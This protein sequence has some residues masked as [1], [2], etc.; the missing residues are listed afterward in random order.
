VGVNNKQRRAAKKRKARA[1]TG[2]AMP[3]GPRWAP[4][5]PELTAADVR[6]LLRDVV[7]QIWDGAT[8]ARRCAG[9][10]LEP[11]RPLT[12]EI[13]RAGVQSFLGDLVRTVTTFGWSPSDL[14]ELT[15]RAAS[16]AH[17][18]LVTGLLREDA[19]RYATD[20]VPVA[21]R[22][23]LHRAGAARPLTLDDVDGMQQALELLATLAQ[24]PSVPP[25]ISAPGTRGPSRRSSPGDDKLLARVQALLAKAEATD[26][27]EEAEALSAKAQE[28]VSRHSLERLLA[29]AATGRSGDEPE[30]RRLWLDAPYVFPKAMLVHV[31][32]DA[33]RCRSVVSEKLGFCTL[34]GAAS[35]LDAVDVLVPSLLVQA[36]VAMAR[37]GRQTDRSGTSRTRSFRQSFLLAYANRIGERLRS[38]DQQAAASSGRGGE[39]VPVLARHREQVDAACDELFPAAVA[40][41]GTVNNAQGWWAGRAAADQASIGTDLQV[42]GAPQHRAAS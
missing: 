30:V 38:A 22:E 26:F 35:D 25:V 40:K 23:D 17:V 15:R 33:N 1:R 31:V 5:E 18:P 41:T 10:L 3:Q 12:P 2:P 32:A 28:L 9:L 14:V 39:L 29:Q 37:C 19:G 21:W 16:E 7:A 27:D 24:L 34:V 13:A 42:T 4:F 6:A 11:G 36:H 8:A 20:R